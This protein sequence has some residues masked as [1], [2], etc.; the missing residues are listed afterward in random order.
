MAWLHADGVRMWYDRGIQLG[1]DWWLKKVVA[2]IMSPSCHGLVFFQTLQSVQS[3][4]CCTEITEARHWRKPIYVVVIE[5]DISARLNAL[6]DAEKSKYGN[7]LLAL[8]RK[9]QRI[10]RNEWAESDYRAKLL[11]DLPRSVRLP[12]PP[13]KELHPEVRYFLGV[14]TAD[15]GSFRALDP[16]A[17]VDRRSRFRALVS[18]NVLCHAFLLIEALDAAGHSTGVAR[19]WPCGFTEPSSDEPPGLQP[20]TWNPIPDGH[21]S[22]EEQPEHVSDWRIGLVVS[23]APIDGLIR[24]IERWMKASPFPGWPDSVAPRGALS[25]P[26]VTCVS[27][28]VAAGAPA[29]VFDLKGELWHWSKV[30]FLP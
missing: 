27:Y 24:R 5:N 12:P 23:T 18:A 4:Y 7:A 29:Q 13:P 19:R 10:T 20:A 11:R 1:T 8:L 21:Q 16:D 28:C 22:F 14:R 25:V 26:P 9:T 17:E 15:N 30:R 6:T 2:Q 3:D